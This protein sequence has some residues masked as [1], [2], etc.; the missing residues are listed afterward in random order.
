M[1]YCHKC[2]TTKPFSDF[3]KCKREKDGCQSRCKACH[4]KYFEKTK[5][6]RSEYGKKYREENKK[7]ISEY[8]KSYYQENKDTI[9]E[10]AKEYHKEYYPQNKEKVLLRNEKWAKSNPDKVRAKFAKRRAKKLQATPDWLTQEH[11]DQIKDIYAHA[12]DCEVVTGDKYHVDH[13]VP[14]QGKDVCGLHVP[15]NLQVLPAEVN[16][17]KSNKTCHL[18]TV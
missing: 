16:Q 15:W 11:L 10:Y 14:L 5:D 2:Q 1:K 17:S 9:S 3:Y 6:R 12:R 8:L 18:N 7:K 4:K 13:I